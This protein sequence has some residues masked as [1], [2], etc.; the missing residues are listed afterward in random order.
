[1][2]KMHVL[3]LQQENLYSSYFTQAAPNGH[4]EPQ[5][6]EAE[7]VE[8]EDDDFSIADYISSMNPRMRNDFRKSNPQLPDLFFMTRAEKKK[9]F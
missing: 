8:P 2:I 3:M 9:F 6:A 1:M 5:E 4:P 7:E